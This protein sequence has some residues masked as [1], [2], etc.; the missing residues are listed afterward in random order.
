[1]P[2]LT[3]LNFIEAAT[4]QVTNIGEMIEQIVNGVKGLDEVSLNIKKADDESEQIIS[5]SSLPNY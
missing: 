1:M 2:L 4:T 5:E 3:S